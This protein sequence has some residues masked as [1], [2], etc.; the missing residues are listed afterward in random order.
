MSKQRYDQIIDEV[1]EKYI[2]KGREEH[3]AFKAQHPEMLINYREDTK[4]RFY[5][6]LKQNKHWFS[7]SPGFAD[8]LGIRIKERK[9]YAIE[10]WN[11]YKKHGGHDG[12]I[13]LIALIVYENEPDN[14][15]V[16]AW[17]N[18]WASNVPTRLVTLT[19]ND[20]TIEVYE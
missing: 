20:E 15:H 5:E 16:H 19:Y 3:A 4:E 10:R 2:A 6:S 17:L 8:D 14:D 13:K 18:T 12:E 7:G 11:W 9:L 1:Y